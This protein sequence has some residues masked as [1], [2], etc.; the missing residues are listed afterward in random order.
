MDKWENLTL[1]DIFPAQA[2][3]VENISLKAQELHLSTS[4]ITDQLTQKMKALNDIIKQSQGLLNSINEAGFYT[5][6]LM[7]DSGGI[8][9]R[10]TSAQDPPPSSAYSA[11]LV[12]AISAPDLPSIV[13]RY[14]KLTDILTKPIEVPK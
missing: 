13:E 5:L 12:I 8:I 3:T 10:I 1:K 4:S 2:K 9:Q 7:P 14:K 6:R 11:G